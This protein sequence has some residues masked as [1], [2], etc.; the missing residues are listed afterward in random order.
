M[1]INY[2]IIN[3]GRECGTGQEWVVR[4]A[5]PS[6]MLE[7]HQRGTDFTSCE[8]DL[9]VWNAPLSAVVLYSVRWAWASGLRI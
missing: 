1:M 8:G 6:S 7:Q 2:S 9:R 4:I 5:D 3:E